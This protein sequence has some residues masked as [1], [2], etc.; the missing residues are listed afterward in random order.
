MTPGEFRLRIRYRKTGRLAWL[1]HLEVAHSLERLIRRAGIPFAVT[2]GFSPHLKAAFGPALPVGT[3]GENEYFDVWLTRYTDATQVIE[4]LQSVSPPD[5]S[6]ISGRYV[7]GRAKSLT[8]VL[9][10]ACYDMVVAG[11]GVTPEAVNEALVRRMSDGEL[12]V[13]HKGKSKVYSLARSVP[14]DARVGGVDGAVTI[15]LVIRMG[16][17]GSLRPEKLIRAALDTAGIQASSIRT[18]RRDTLVE[19]EDGSWSRPM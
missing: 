19:E 2:Q 7:D 10:I 8:S 4:T 18:T 1:S 17:E 13:E 11:E 6:P 12:K 15:D 9:T 5:L 14:K 3:G 16:P